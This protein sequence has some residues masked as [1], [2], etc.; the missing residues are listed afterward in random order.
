MR[1]A[2]WLGGFVVGAVAGWWLLPGPSGGGDW[3]RPA[4]GAAAERGAAGASARP[5]GEPG[6]VSPGRRASAGAVPPATGFAAAEREP[7]LRA[8]GAEAPAASDSRLA[9]GDPGAAGGAPAAPPPEPPAEVAQDLAAF[10]PWIRGGRAGEAAAALRRAGRSSEAAEIDAIEGL[11]RGGHASLL[12]GRL[13]EARDRWGE[14]LRREEALLGGGVVTFPGREM[15]ARLAAA[16]HERAARSEK[17]GQLQ[18]AF[19]LWQEAASFDPTHLE[20]LAGL[21]RL[22]LRAAEIL[23]GEP[24]CAELA[25]ILATTRRESPTHRLAAE[26]MRGCD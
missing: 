11:R 10:E 24:G 23:A 7:A 17:R 12:A 20:T 26:R 21:Q 9:R 3:E 16:L 22:E 13:E 2:V 18:A 6:P 19:A 1:I 5:E 8:G 4:A 14:A 15:R 25:S